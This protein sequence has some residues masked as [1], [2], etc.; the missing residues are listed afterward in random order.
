MMIKNPT[1]DGC[2]PARKYP[3]NVTNHRKSGQPETTNLMGLDIV[4]YLSI[5]HTRK[6]NSDQW[7]T[8]DSALQAIDEV[9]AHDAGPQLTAKAIMRLR[10]TYS[11]EQTQFIAQQV[12]LRTQAATRFALANKMLFTDRSLQQA[13][14]S[15]IAQFKAA[16]IQKIAPEARHVTDLCC[17]LGGDLQALATSFNVTGVDLD[18]E[19]C[20]IAKYNASLC[21]PQEKEVAVET[22]TADACQLVLDTDWV[23]I[24]PDRRSDGQR[25]TEIASLAPGLDFLNRLTSQVGTS[26]HGL[27]MKFAPASSIPE[28]WLPQCQLIWIQSRNE[29]RQQLALFA[30][31]RIAVNTRT[32]VAVDGR[33]I[34]KWEFSIPNDQMVEPGDVAFN[35]TAGQFL[36]EPMPGIL[37]AQMAP[38]WGAV[39]NLKYIHSSVAYFTSDKA[40]DLPGGTC[41]EVLQDLPFNLKQIRQYIKQ[42]DIG[43][44]EIKKRGINDTPEKIRKLLKPKGEHE[45]TLIIAGNPRTKNQTRVYVAQRVKKS[46]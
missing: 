3:R 4:Y 6:M 36:Y 14:D 7:L 1:F 5:F 44:L 31:N 16:L 37:A 18:P 42:H 29:C 28:H 38:S 15:G 8:S 43:R 21:I 26:L 32:A 45:A 30:K 10:R 11:F 25:H 9:C 20:A 27:S 40:M 24:D 17:G 41:Y 2:M 19:I 35:G 34:P 22:I 39:H 13:T 46:V 12:K 23:H 33:G